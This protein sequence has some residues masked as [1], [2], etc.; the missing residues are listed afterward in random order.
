[1]NEAPRKVIAHV[2][3]GSVTLKLTLGS[4]VLAKS[5]KD[6]CLTPFLGVY[7]KKTNA[8]PLTAEAVSRV[9]ID[10]T[11]VPCIEA[12]GASV[13]PKESHKIELFFSPSPVPTPSPAPAPA[14]AS[15][16]APAPAPAPVPAPVPASAAVAPTPP[17]PPP[18]GLPM[19]SNTMP[20]CK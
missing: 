13:L 4:K 14:P 15:A 20:K 8:E 3:C 11:A 19:A 18:S 10:G 6:G 17:P 7:N 5:L 16:P 1:M 12:T 2:T 9:E